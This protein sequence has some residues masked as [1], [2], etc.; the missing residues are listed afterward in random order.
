[1]SQGIDPEIIRLFKKI[2]NGVS[3]LVLW[4]LITMTLGIYLGWA[5]IYDSFHPFNGIFYTWFVVSL[6]GLVYYI[7]KVW[8]K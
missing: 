2:I 4:A 8:K 7:I 5:F 6:G 3:A 1:M